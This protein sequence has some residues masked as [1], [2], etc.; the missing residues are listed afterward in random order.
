MMTKL[1]NVE[2]GMWNVQAQT[3]VGVGYV[4][5]TEKTRTTQVTLKTTKTKTRRRLAGL[6]T[7]T[8]V[9]MTRTVMMTVT[10]MM[11]AIT[12]EHRTATGMTKILRDWDSPRRKTK[13]E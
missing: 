6:G 8:T 4:S 11:T 5:R 9:M 1:M 7:R 2:R 3:T 12:A 10:V 13:D